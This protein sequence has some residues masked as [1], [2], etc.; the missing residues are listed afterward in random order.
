MAYA[1]STHVELL[2]APFLYATQQ[3]FRPSYHREVMLASDSAPV[4]D[5]ALGKID[6]PRR[7]KRVT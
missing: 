6:P 7:I 1:T 2:Y 4:W 3:N 5:A